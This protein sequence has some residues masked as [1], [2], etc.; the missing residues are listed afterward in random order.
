VH[1]N[2][3]RQFVSLVLEAVQPYLKLFNPIEAIL[4]LFTP[5]PA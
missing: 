2:T 3:S 5:N 1:N 4:L